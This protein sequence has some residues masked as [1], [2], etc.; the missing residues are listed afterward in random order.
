M[1]L[2]QDP[3]SGAATITP[4]DTTILSGVRGLYIGTG[5]G[6]VAVT[7]RSG[8][9]VTFP[10]VPAGTFMPIRVT[11]VMETNTDATSIVALF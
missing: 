6:A 5:G 7:M 9:V 4:S 10:A 8:Q 11:K 1:A 3:A 2:M